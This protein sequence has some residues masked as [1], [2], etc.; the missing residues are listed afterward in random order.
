MSAVRDRALE[1]LEAH[2]AVVD[3]PPPSQPAGTPKVSRNRRWLVRNP[4]T[5]RWKLYTTHG[6]TWQYN[7]TLNAWEITTSP[8]FNISDLHGERD[9]CYA[10]SVGETAHTVQEQCSLRVTA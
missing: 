5:G 8:N 1:I 3:I 9:L 2:A 10:F 6:P 4:A 7:F